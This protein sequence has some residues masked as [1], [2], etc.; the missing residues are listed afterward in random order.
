MSATFDLN[1]RPDYDRVLQDIADYVLDYG[2][3]STEALDTARLC[4]MD[5]LGCGLLALRFPECTKH[6]GPLVEGTVVP[7]GARVPG[8]SFRLDPVKAAWDIGAMVRWLDYNDTWL[9]AEWGHPSDNLGGILAVADHLSQRRRAQGEAPL[10]MR[11]VLQAM[12]M[13][14][15][16]QGVLA[17][18]N[19]FN[20]VG[21]DHVILVKVAST[22]VCARLMGAD[23][24]QLL[25]AL[26]HAFVDGQALRTYRHAPNA[27]SR[28]SWAAGDATSRG[29]RLADIALRGEMGIPGVLTAPQWGFYDVLFSHTN[30]DLAAKPA[31]RRRF[32]LPQGFGCCV[33]ENILFKISFPAE[34]HAQTA[35]EAALRLHPQVRDRLHEIDR[36][37]ITTHE[38]AIRIISKVG[39]LANPADRDHC[40]Q[41]MVAVPLAFGELGAESYEDDFHAAHPIIDELRGKMAVVEDARYSREYLDADKRSIAN[42]VQVFFKDGSSTEQVAVEYPLGH[43]R[44]RAEGI[45]LLEEKFRANLATRFPALRCARILALCQDQARLEATA[46]DRFVE[47]L[48]N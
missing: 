39:P 18:E 9:A 32:H 44:R 27:G 30:K 24:E 36:I 7:H 23:R 35:C 16:I 21:L 2:A 28:K 34:F 26:S 4:L 13:A 20:R 25:S 43:R 14:H 12:I 1:V 11:A 22:V 41:Y 47:L 5:T 10:S 31:D 46:V 6:L 29:V 33:M 45:P 15:E 48:V 38:S 3:F 8:T 37:V 42:A 17:L 19:S 40:L